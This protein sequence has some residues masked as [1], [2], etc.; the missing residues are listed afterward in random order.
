METKSDLLQTVL[1]WPHQRVW[2]WL[3]GLII[4][5]PIDGEFF[6]WD[7]FAFAAATRAREERSLSWANIALLVYG[8]IAKRSPDG[9]A[10][11]LTY[12]AMNLRAWMICELGAREG[13]TVL[14]PAVIVAWFRRTA[15]LSFEEV[16]QLVS[17]LD[18]RITP[19]DT[20]R[21]LRSIKNALNVLRSICKSGVLR[22]H[23][24]LIDWLRIRRR[25][26]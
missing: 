26:P 24:E 23:P 6:N 15:T 19:I 12:S 14:D 13:D 11:S 5:E 22:K 10:E 1:K 25:L 16:V 2:A 3:D 21:K 4:G 17:P 8:D 18:L 7:L 20:I 9:I